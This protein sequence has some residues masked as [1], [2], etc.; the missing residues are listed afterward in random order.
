MA[1][2]AGVSYSIAQPIVNSGVNQRRE[3]ENQES[4]EQLRATS[5]PQRDQP[6]NNKPADVPAEQSIS[7]R[8]NVSVP[9]SENTTEENTTGINEQ[10]VLAAEQQ[11]QQ[12]SIES[13]AKR[14]ETTDQSASE[15]SVGKTEQ[16]QSQVV[17]EQLESQNP[18]AGLGLNSGSIIDVTA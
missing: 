11:I 3:S 1:D 15:T 14:S 12:T 4:A 10:V 6:L 9:T 8:L 17:T 7:A 2:I 16:E 18:E 5:A 13:N